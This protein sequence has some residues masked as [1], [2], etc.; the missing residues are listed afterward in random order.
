MDAQNNIALTASRQSLRMLKVEIKQRLPNFNALRPTN[1][2][3][4]NSVV[5]QFDA[6]IFTLSLSHDKLKEALILLA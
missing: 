5:S 3:T 6:H 4:S 2:D 1:L